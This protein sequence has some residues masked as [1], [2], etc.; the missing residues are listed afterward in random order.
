M[1]EENVLDRSKVL[2]LLN[3]EP[4]TSSAERLHPWRHSCARSFDFPLLR[5]WD[6]Y[7][8]SQPNTYNRMNSRSPDRPLNTIEARQT[9]LTTHINHED[10]TPTPYISFTSSPAV[11]ED[12]AKWRKAKRGTQTLTAIN[13]NIRLG[14]GLPILDLDT[15]ME[16]YKI[17]NPYGNRGKYSVDHYICLWQVTD[18]EIIGHW[19]WDKLVESGQWYQDIVKPAFQESNQSFVFGAADSDVSLLMSRLRGKFLVG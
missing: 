6:S 3:A 9:T 10:W 12:L 15:E 11:I 4:A 18:E 17:S 13:P 8:G 14:S 7:S 2:V 19:N 5:I 16:H 1:A